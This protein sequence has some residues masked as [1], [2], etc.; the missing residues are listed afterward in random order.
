[1]TSE[2]GYPGLILAASSS[3][4]GKT[5]LSLGL[6][7]LMI[8][9]GIRIAPAKTG[10]DY[11]D[12]AFHTVASGEPS[13]NLDPWAM[14]P[15]AIKER[16]IKQACDH[17]LLF[18]EGVMGLFDGAANGQGSTATLARILELP[19][20]LVLDVKGQA[21]TAAAIA[22]GIKLHDPKVKIG[23]VILNRVGTE[24][25]EMMLRDAFDKVSIP[26]VGAVRVS[27]DLA[28]PSRHLGLV[29]AS[30]YDDLSGKIDKI[31]DHVEK[32][33]D[34]EGMLKIARSAVCK[35]PGNDSN[36][37]H[38]LAPL[39]KHIAIA[40]DAAFTFI[41]PHVL[42]EW[43]EQ[44]AEISFFSPLN[45]EAPS[46]DADAIYLPGGYPELYLEQLAEACCFKAG[47]KQAAD[48][49]KLIFGECGGYMVLGREITSKEGE[50]F[51]ML[52]LLPISTS[53]HH[54]K[55]KLGYRKLE[56]QSDLPWPPKL[57]AHEFHF[58]QITWMGEAE[59]LFHAWASTGRDVGTMGQKV[60]SVHGS[61]AHIIGPQ[62]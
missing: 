58:S 55:L 22:H 45:D 43:K 51:S 50:T 37:N 60:G 32:Y 20:L 40:K 47:L 1:M 2:Q 18:V 13:I 41:Y 48:A 19:V 34:L 27:D 35:H 38:Q 5:T 6:Q 12:P 24:V 28:L 17:D 54:P 53:F 57:N 49:H 7:R 36:H 59:P 16:A 42:S 52:D 21:Q 8:R 62:Y 46:S 4:S 14:S 56:H 29:Q 31:A 61:F 26:V 30:E 39:G 3:N 15:E 25:H 23:G 33:V 9:K 11:I 10:P 44:G